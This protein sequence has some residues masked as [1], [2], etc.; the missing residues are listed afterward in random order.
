M[1]TSNDVSKKWKGRG[2]SFTNMLMKVEPKFG[3]D[4]YRTKAQNHALEEQLDVTIIKQVQQSIENKQPITIDLP[5]KNINRTVGAMLSHEIATRYGHAGLPD[6]T[7]RINMNGF[8]GQSFGAFLSKGVELSLVGASNDYIGK[9]LSGGR[10]IVKVPENVS[11]DSGKN[12]IVGNTTFYGAIDGE[13]YINGTAGERFCV[14]N[15]GANVVIEGVGDHGCEYMTGGRAVILGNIG[16]NFAAGM[17]GGIAYI[18]DSEKKSQENINMEMVEI[19]SLD[20]EA[21][22]EVHTMI[23]NH[24]K[25]TSSKRSFYILNDWQK[26]KKHFIKIIPTEYKKAIQKLSEEKL[27]N[28]I[29]NLEL[30]AN[31]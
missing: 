19:E 18:W 28:S 29:N 22:Q 16:R 7:I 15:S 2:I 26:E 12:I 4:I 3:T 21:F 17:S 10:I 24:Y 13:A 20:E 1:K 9:G 5:V 27:K 8:A 30:K 11:F 31:G 14:R 6:A 25:Y 23:S